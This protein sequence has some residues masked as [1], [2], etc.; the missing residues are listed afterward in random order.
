MFIIL[1][2][3]I[4]VWD[5]DSTSILFSDGGKMDTFFFTCFNPLSLIDVPFLFLLFQVFY[6]VL[7][8]LRNPTSTF[9]LIKFSELPDYK[10]P[11]NLG[12]ISSC[13]SVVSSFEE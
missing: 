7:F 3:L 13:G 12:L 4:K 1:S 10:R 9:Q 8:F 5:N 11:I 2:L 6:V